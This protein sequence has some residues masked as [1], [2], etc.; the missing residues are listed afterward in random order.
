M[1]RKP[2]SVFLITES[3]APP[4]IPTGGALSV[5]R[6]PLEDG[7]DAQAVAEQHLL[8]TPLGA[9]VYFIEDTKVD[10]YTVHPTLEPVD[11]PRLPDPTDADPLVHRT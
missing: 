2:S 4:G 1:P 3:P 11:D 5:R 7:Q 8:Q 10:A 6:V 9:T